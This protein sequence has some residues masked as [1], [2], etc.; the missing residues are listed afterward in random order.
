MLALQKYKVVLN[1]LIISKNNFQFHPLEFDFYVFLSNLILILLIL[2]YFSFNL[3]LIGF[4]FL[5]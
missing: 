1:L 4:Y 2:I 5:I 3:F